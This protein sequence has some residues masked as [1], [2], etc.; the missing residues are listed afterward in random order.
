[1]KPRLFR[2]NVKEQDSSVLRRGKAEREK[3]FLSRV[4]SDKPRVETDLTCH[5][6]HW[7]VFS[8]LSSLSST[9]K[10]VVLVIVRLELELNGICL[11]EIGFVSNRVGG[12]QYSFIFRQRDMQRKIDLVQ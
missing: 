5:A 6:I 12:T 8:M 11:A 4:L 3:S 7:N 9:A 10:K 2:V 1:M